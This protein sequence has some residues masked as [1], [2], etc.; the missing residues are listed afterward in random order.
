VQIFVSEYV[1]GGGLLGSP[2]ASSLR[3]EALLMLRRLVE[4]LAELA[5]VQVAVA[6]DPAI[7]LGSL[8]ASIW[9]LRGAADAW[10]LWA[11]LRARADAV[12]PLAPECD[13][14]LASITADIVRSG[15]TLLGSAL[16]AVTIATSKRRTAQHLA[17]HG[18]AVIPTTG[19]ADSLPA[20]VGGW[21]A[22]PDDGAGCTDT[23][24]FGHADAL[25]RWQEAQPD[26]T[27]VV[28]PFIRGAPLSASLIMQ[29]GVA[30]LLSC[31]RQIITLR[32]GTFH[33]GGSVVGGAE[34]R[35]D[36]LQPLVAAVAAA[37]PTLW[38]YVGIDIIDGPG[39]PVVVD[40]NPRLTTS[41]AGLRASIGRN[42]AALV[43]ALLD[44]RLDRLIEPL[45][46]RP[47]EIRV[48][49]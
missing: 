35:R 36:A 29:D 45:A 2:V 40:V 17:N 26:R 3:S 24:W 8:P 4:D 37:L 39:G 13:G 41:Y 23:M 6:R 15:R 32:D 43:L 14:A 44:Q 46:P 19:L 38:G 12:W 31:N 1:T 27:I 34:H 47:I 11:A 18:I 48:P 7:D 20:S 42:P 25:A 5:D 16:G 49:G 10:A 21:V 30:W 33:Y 22:K 9:E 28:Q